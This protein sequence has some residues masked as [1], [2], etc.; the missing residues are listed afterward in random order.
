MSDFSVDVAEYDDSD[1]VVVSHSIGFA[2][3]LVSDDEIGGD[4]EDN[5]FVLSSDDAPKSVEKFI[6]P[7][8]EES[9]I[10]I[11]EPTLIKLVDPTSNSTNEMDSD[12]N[13]EDWNVTDSAPILNS[14]DRDLNPVSIAPPV[15]ASN[16]QEPPHSSVLPQM[17]SM[18]QNEQPSINV[19]TPLSPKPVSYTHLT[20]PRRG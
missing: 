13:N 11:P 1:D 4:V 9:E 18:P 3:Q 8:E 15:Q 6:V 7:E 12:L 20:L 17:P 5:E 2:R 14:E 19:E 16:V 10:P